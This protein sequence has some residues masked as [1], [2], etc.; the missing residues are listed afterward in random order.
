MC[1]YCLK[2]QDECKQR[3][4]STPSGV[5]FDFGQCDEDDRPCKADDQEG[6]TTD[7]SMEGRVDSDEVTLVYT[8]E[9]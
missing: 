8:F 1:C 6:V 3:A 9:K 2:L 4:C 5:D 7:G